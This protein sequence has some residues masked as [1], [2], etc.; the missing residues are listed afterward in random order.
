MLNLDCDYEIYYYCPAL[1]IHYTHNLLTNYIMNKALIRKAYLLYE[2]KNTSRLLMT[3]K[4]DFEKIY[5]FYII[6]ACCIILLC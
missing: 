3:R 2:Y 1:T 6:S 4:Q 5:Y